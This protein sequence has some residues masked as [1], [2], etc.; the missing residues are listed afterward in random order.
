MMSGW[1][2]RRIVIE[3]LVFVFT[4]IREMLKQLFHRLGAVRQ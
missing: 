2:P 1:L 4:D 3:Y